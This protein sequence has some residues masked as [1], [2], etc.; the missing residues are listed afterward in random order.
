VKVL[1]HC[2]TTRDALALVF[3]PTERQSREFC[4]YVRQVDTACGTPLK[5]KKENE[6]EIEW[7]NGSRMLSLPDRHQGVV[8]YSPTLVVIDEAS[9]VS[10]QLYKSVRPMLGLGGTMISISTPFGQ[11]GWFFDLWNTPKRLAR[12]Q[13]YRVTA[14]YC[15]RISAE[16]L[17]E[18]LDELGERWFRQEWYTVFEEAADAVFSAKHIRRMFAVE[19]AQPLFAA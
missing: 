15:P 1:H 13:H 7:A 10:D 6:S 3:A 18:E 19:D 5:R 16:F 8:G 11:R 14:D 2:L 17:A 9:R 4:R 12:Y